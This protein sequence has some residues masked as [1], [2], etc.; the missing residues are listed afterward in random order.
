[1][2]T[3][4]RPPGW[5]PGGASARMLGREGELF[6]LQFSCDVLPY[7][8]A[9]GAMPLPPYIKRDDRPEDR[10]RYQTIFASS[11]ASRIM[12]PRNQRIVSLIPYGWPPSL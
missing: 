2:N 12:P 9:H 10:E 8:E 3:N 7:F 4:F 1:M 11:R 5:G 6:R